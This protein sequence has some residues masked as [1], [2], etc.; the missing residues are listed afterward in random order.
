MAL[1][2]HDSDPN[3]AKTCFVHIKSGGQTLFFKWGSFDPPDPV[4]PRSMRT[5]KLRVRV[6]P[7]VGSGRNFRH[8]CTAV[9]VS[10][11]ATGT[12]RVAEMVYPHTSSIG[13]YDSLYTTV[14]EL[15]A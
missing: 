5:G 11:S 15:L 3:A 12:G 14:P 13:L 8:G 10:K 9:R 6:Y 2:V 1:M 7:R 4:L